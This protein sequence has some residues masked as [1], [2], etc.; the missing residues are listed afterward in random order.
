[1]VYSV[2]HSTDPAKLVLALRAYHMVTSALFFLDD[3]PTL[4]AI[5]SLVLKSFK[6]CFHGFVE[7][8]FAVFA[9]VVW[10]ATLHA[11]LILTLLTYT[12]VRILPREDTV[13]LLL[14][15]HR[16]GPFTFNQLAI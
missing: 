14:H 15:G 3:Q 13:G 2:F 8:C 16:E 4:R 10:E 11:N 1:M 6:V 5:S 12:S 7:L 9:L